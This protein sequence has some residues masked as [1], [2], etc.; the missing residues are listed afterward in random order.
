M[1]FN[2]FDEYLA[3]VT[4]SGK[5]REL[6]RIDDEPVEKAPVKE[7]EEAEDKPAEDTA[8]KKA[9]AKRGAKK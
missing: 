5:V 2:S 4:H 7:A 1:H 6:K 9:P 8:K 3:A